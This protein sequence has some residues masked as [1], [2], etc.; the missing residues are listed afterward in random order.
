MERLQPRVQEIRAK[1][2]VPTLSTVVDETDE[3]GRPQEDQ[4]QFIEEK[5]ENQVTVIE[6]SETWDSSDK[7]EVSETR[8]LS[9]EPEESG[10]KS[11]EL[12]IKAQKLEVGPAMERD[13][14]KSFMERRFTQ[15]KEKLEKGLHT[16][17]KSVTEEK[18][19][20]HQ[21]I[22]VLSHY[23]EKV[24]E[25]TKKLGTSEQQLKNRIE[26]SRILEQDLQTAQNKSTE[27]AA[28]LKILTQ[29]N[30]RSKLQNQADSIK[31]EKLDKRRREVEYDLK[32]QPIQL[33]QQQHF[34]TQSQ[35]EQ[36]LRA[37]I[38]IKSQKTKELTI[39]MER[40]EKDVREVQ[41]LAISMKRKLQ[42]TVLADGEIREELEDEVASMKKWATKW[43][44]SELTCSR[45][46]YE[47]NALQKEL[48]K[49]I[50]IGTPPKQ[51][52]KDL[53]KKVKPR[54]A[55]HALLAQF[56]AERIFLQGFLTL[57]EAAKTSPV[58]PF[59][60][61]MTRLLELLLRSLYPP[62]ASQHQL[63]QSNRRPS[64]SARLARTYPPASRRRLPVHGRHR[65]SSRQRVSRRPQQAP[66]PTNPDH[67]R[68]TGTHCH[69]HVRACALL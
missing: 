33:Q 64:R 5:Q 14:G 26:A 2:R 41:Q 20:L 16:Q 54:I 67:D 40:Q 62:P 34:R 53:L 3:A 45:I 15:E 35:I 66:P 30:I 55:V 10:M 48:K 65:R 8:L 61:S 4:P 6:E 39:K 69:D 52:T 36:Q 13:I 25:L 47:S 56:F 50:L 58:A 29:E 28:T 60:A 59:S 63:T 1:A 57:D 46:E 17:L 31:I 24:K 68:E 7:H 51:S 43:A 18:E 9:V 11:H 38:E 19:N 44:V 22:W 49:V 23:H 12:P 21:Q 27:L 42:P 37:E 32:E